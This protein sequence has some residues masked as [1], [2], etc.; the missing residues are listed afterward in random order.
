MQKK[1]VVPYEV[2]AQITY[3]HIWLTAMSNMRNALPGTAIAADNLKRALK[4]LDFDALP[5]N[6]PSNI[7]PLPTWSPEPP[8]AA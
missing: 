7:L 8:E 4:S 6:H 1:L 2:W 3:A 5:A